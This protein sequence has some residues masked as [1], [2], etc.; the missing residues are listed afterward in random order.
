VT[1]QDSKAL[2]YYSHVSLIEVREGATRWR[3]AGNSAVNHLGGVASLLH[4]HLR[5]AGQRLAIFLERCGIAD[6]KNLWMSGN[7]EV[8]L[9]AYSAGAIRFYVQPLACRGGSNTRSPDHGL[10]Y[11]PLAAYNDTIV[12]NL[13]HAMSEPDLNT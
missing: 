8:T 4:R 7:R 3:S 12:V 2:P 13:L 10:A 9:N 11:D 1:F 6:D 5:N